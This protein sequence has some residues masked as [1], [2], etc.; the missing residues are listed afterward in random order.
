[1]RQR[2]AG[3]EM[4]DSEAVD[5]IAR[6]GRRSEQGSKIDYCC[7]LM[8]KKDRRAACFED[9]ILPIRQVVGV[10]SVEIGG[11][12]SNYCASEVRV[13]WFRNTPTVYPFTLPRI[14]T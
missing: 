4:S 6:Q 14:K 8:A 5:T 13:C 9:V 10:S 7:V 1:M 3:D 2:N 12:V 11:P